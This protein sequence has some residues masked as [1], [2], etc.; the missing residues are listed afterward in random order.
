MREPG[1]A[2]RESPAEPSSQVFE[3]VSR[4]FRNAAT[5]IL[6]F[7]IDTVVLGCTAECKEAADAPVRVLTWSGIISRL[8]K[9]AGV[10]QWQNRSFPSFGRGFDSHRPLQKSR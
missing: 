1:S 2:W 10:V 8:R 9:R 3:G 6:S 5:F 4:H 7:G